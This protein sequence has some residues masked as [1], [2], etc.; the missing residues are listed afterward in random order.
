[1]SNDSAATAWSG[2]AADASSTA[3]PLLKTLSKLREAE[4]TIIC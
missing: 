4:Q 2:D 3:T 1:M